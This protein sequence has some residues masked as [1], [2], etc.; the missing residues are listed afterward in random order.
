MIKTERFITPPIGANSFLAYDDESKNGLL[1][2]LGGDFSQIQRAAAAK[3]VTIRAVLLTHGHFDHTGGGRDAQDSGIPVYIS[4]ADAE[5]L[6]GKGS[7]ASEFG[8]PL[9]PYTADF[10]FR[11]G[12]TL[13][14]CGMD[15]QTLAT[16]GHTS[17][18]CSFIIGDKIFTG[19]TLFRLSFGRTDMPD[20]D[21]A[22]IKKSLYK[23]FNLS[24]NYEVYCGH[25]ENT[26][27]FFER[28]YNPINEY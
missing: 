15:V 28:E 9:K 11:G 13:K 19:D 2:D 21:F 7:L 20:G 4:A 6:G 10:T 27:L 26:Q 3:G 1:I 24:K 23:L 18:S 16:P 8:F 25:G 22:E 17:G 5:K 14:I 12:E